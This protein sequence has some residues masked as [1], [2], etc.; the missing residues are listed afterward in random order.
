[1]LETRILFIDTQ[2]FVKSNFNFSSRPFSTLK[3]LCQEGELRYLLTSVVEQ[4]VDGKIEDSIR[5]ALSSLQSF[6]K[7]ARVLSTIEDEHLSSLFSDVNEPEVYQKASQVFQQYNADCNY[8][9]VEADAIDPEHLLELYFQQKPPFGIGKKKAEFPDAISLLSL[10]SYLEDNEKI[11]IIS[12]DKDLKTYCEGNDRLITLDSLE[13]LLDVYNQHT[14]ART[15]KVK[16]YIV[17]ESEQIQRMFRDYV[18]DC[19][20]YN[21]STWEDAE[22]EEYEVKN[23]SDFEINVID[24]DDEESQVTVEAS[25]DLFVE[26]VGPDFANGT[27]DKEDGF[28]YTFGSTKREETFTL[29]LTAE[30]D[31]QYTFENGELHEPRISTFTIPSLRG[32]VEVSV[33]EHPEPDWY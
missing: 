4:E 27:Y 33:E 14:N 25:V 9:Y 18:E 19:D 20:I 8:E 5:E 31:L 24:I 32:S 13:K 28:I 7:K 29:T 23:V 10:E 30:L 15:E 3:E 17:A 11:Y 21:S 1:M 12:D 26:V 6:K 2:Y 16:E 22:V